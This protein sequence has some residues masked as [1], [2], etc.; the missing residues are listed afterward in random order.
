[1][2]P[3]PG[4]RDLDRH[5]TIL[6]ALALTSASTA[7][8]R[9]IDITTTGAKSGQPRRIEIWFYR[10]HQ[11]LYL[12]STPARRDWYANLLA[13]PRFTFHLK[14]GPRAD[15]PASAT[16]VLDPHDR[17][18][19]FTSIIDDLNQPTDPRRPRR[20]RPST[21]RMGHQQPP[22]AHHL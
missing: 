5:T 11:N 8:Q 9:T 6:T 1:M 10:A 2:S 4:G 22:D 3:H 17:A 18:H 14:N 16:P 21:D 7:R 19:I 15:L 13:D 12:S 20:A